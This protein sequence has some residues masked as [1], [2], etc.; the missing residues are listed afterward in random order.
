M[1]LVDTVGESFVYRPY[2]GDPDLA[3]RCDYVET[4]DEGAKHPSC[5]VG[6]I[7]ADPAIGVTVET[8]DAMDTLEWP[9]FLAT[10]WTSPEEVSPEIGGQVKEILEA[11]GY[12]FTVKAA[13][14]LGSFQ[15][16]QDNRV[17][18]GVVLRFAT[19]IAALPSYPDEV[20]G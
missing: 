6:K 2:G 13:A 11:A 20:V 15:V 7:L 17:P 12:I 16:H 5:G 3:V 14:F 9:G 8:L 4:D 19:R 18:Y 10:P 1:R